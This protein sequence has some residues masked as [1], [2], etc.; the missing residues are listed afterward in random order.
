ML[1]GKLSD[2]F[3]RTSMIWLAKAK[4]SL[5]DTADAKELRRVGFR[6]GASQVRDTSAAAGAHIKTGA[7]A[8]DR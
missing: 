7:G 6:A 8:T 5:C 1:P 4:K 2:F 3:K